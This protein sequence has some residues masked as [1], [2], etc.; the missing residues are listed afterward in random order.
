M[1]WLIQSTKKNKHWILALCCFVSLA[2]GLMTGCGDSIGN[3]DPNKVE[4]TARTVVVEETNGTTVVL[5][6]TKESTN[7]YKGMHLV[8]G[9]DVTVQ[10]ISDLTM[11]FDM[12]KYMYAEEETHFWLKEASGSQKKSSTVIYLDEGAT[13]NRIV[14]PLEEGAVYRVDTP[15]S[16][17]AVRGTV[18][19]VEVRKGSDDKVYT[20][21]AV[22][23]GAVKVDLKTTEG[24]YNGVTETISA[25]TAAVVRA[26]ETFSEFVVGRGGKI[27]VPIDYASFPVGTLKQIINYIDDGDEIAADRDELEALIKE[28]LGQN[29]SHDAKV[30]PETKEVKKECKHKTSVWTTKTKATCTHK[31]LKVK[32]CTTCGKIVNSRHTDKISH[33]LGEEIT[34]P[35][36]CT[37]DGTV[38][39]KCTLCGCTVTKEVLEPTGHQ[40]GNWVV[41][42]QPTYSAEGTETKYCTVC[43]EVIETRAIPQLIYTRA[44]CNH[45]VT[46]W[47]VDKPATCTTAGRQSGSCSY[48]GQ[49]ITEPIQ[50]TGHEWSA[51]NT[52]VAATCTK[53]GS[54]EHRCAK[55]SATETRS[56]Q[57]TGHEWSDTWTITSPATCTKEGSQQHNCTKCNATETQT[58]RA[59]G[60]ETY[61]DRWNLETPATCTTDGKETQQCNRCSD[62]IEQTISAK[63]HTWGEW[64]QTPEGEEKRSCTTCHEEET[65]TTTT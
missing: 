60:H 41:T 56:I 9:N 49:H 58:I 14:N 55:C 30:K 32:K 1:N 6:E 16:T 28:K 38:T 37:Q 3:S 5:D 11:L 12:D 61:G 57:A 7:A 8:S 15:N 35:P 18:F 27:A 43:N 22:L 59:L 25:G 2:I 45:N 52:T 42:L 23:D 33:K 51:W 54:E 39:A 21:L 31:G 4:E 44:I 64:T 48:C 10:Q 62:L 17:M 26:D 40:P 65:R 36:T 46:T 24:E 47:T 29:D 53:D 34:T 13:L 63:G 19:R 50:A 20:Y